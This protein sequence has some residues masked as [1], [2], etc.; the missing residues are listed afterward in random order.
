VKLLAAAILCLSLAQVN[1]QGVP[2]LRTQRE[3]KAQIEIQAPVDLVWTILVEF[4]TYEIWNPY[5]YPVTGELHTGR[6]LDVT[7]HAGDRLLRYEPVV[8]TVLPKH[9]VS[10]G[11]R[12]PG[13]VFERVQIF[14]LTELTPARVRL[15]SR[16]R[17]QGLLLPLY[18]R[19]PEDAQ[20]GLEMMNRALRNRAEL[21]NYST[22]R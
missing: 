9:E 19:G 22:K 16:E 12:I 14:T 15:T 3:V 11:G 5:I 1:I 8:L 21:L 6:L 20:R 2:D 10:W 13:G 17:F 18:G 7:L 4:P